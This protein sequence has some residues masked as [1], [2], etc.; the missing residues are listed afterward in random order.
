M[1]NDLSDMLSDCTATSQPLIISAHSVRSMFHKCNIRK[2]SGPDMITGKFLKV[3]ADQLCDIFTDLFN[4][5]LTQHKVPILWKES[6]VV[7]EYFLCGQ[8]TDGFIL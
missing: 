6:I 5:S 7:P 4:S 8:D 2:S 1:H 3:C